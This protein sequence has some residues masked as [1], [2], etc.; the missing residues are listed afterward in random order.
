[1]CKLK[2]DGEAIMFKND[3]LFPQIKEEHQA[4]VPKA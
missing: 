3:Y 1:M 4:K 2:E